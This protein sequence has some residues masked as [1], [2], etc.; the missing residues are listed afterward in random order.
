M[1]D[2]IMDVLVFSGEGKCRIFAQSPSGRAEGTAG[3]PANIR[4][5]VIELQ[6]ALLRGSSARRG[7]A[8]VGLGAAAD[9]RIIGEMGARLYS[10]L[11]TGDVDNLYKKSL[12]DAA[13]AREALRIKLRIDGPSELATVPWETLYDTKTRQFLSAELRTL[14][15]RSVETN[16]INRWVPKKLNILGMISGPTSYN[17]SQLPALDVDLERSKIESCLNHLIKDLGKATLSW[18]MSGSYKDLRRRLNAGNA[19]HE[20]EGWTVFHFIGHG[21]FDERTKQGY[22][23]LEEGGGSIGEARY[24]DTLAPL[25]TDAGGP[26]LIVLNSCNGARSASGDLFSSLAAALALAGVPSVIAMQFPVS[27]EMAIEFSARFYEYLAD[28]YPIQKALAQTRI[29]LRGQRISEWISPVLFMQTPD[30]QL[31]TS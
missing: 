18:T 11:F 29:D 15:T 20:G 7:N 2:W 23:I 1:K 9:E 4:M 16:T 24:P 17:G 22:L 21:D 14:F 8:I 3:V 27:D 12:I 30:G 13:N 19:G 31:L 25:L 26:Q 10:F 5:E 6:E 28:N